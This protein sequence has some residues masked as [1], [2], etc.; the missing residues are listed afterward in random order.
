M[1]FEAL[2][3]I[4]I[5]WSEFSSFLFCVVDLSEPSNWILEMHFG[6]YEC[7]TIWV[8]SG[9]AMPFKN[10]LHF[11]AI[12]CVHFVY[13]LVFLSLFFS[14]FLSI[15]MFCLN[16]LTWKLTW[17]KKW[18]LLLHKFVS[19]LSRSR[20]FFLISVYKLHQKCY[21]WFVFE[22]WQRNKISL[23]FPSDGMEAML[24]CSIVNNLDKLT[25][26][27]ARKNSVDRQYI[28]AYFIICC[29]NR[30]K[31]L[32]VFLFDFSAHLTNGWMDS[33]QMRTK[34]I[35]L[36]HLLFVWFLCSSVSVGINNSNITN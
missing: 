28:V 8:S 25:I 14:L 4:I 3:Y 17:I 33:R 27:T 18:I 12:V 31:M 20:A 19:M 2:S 13:V 32:W 36:V 24:V 1:E 16:F 35:V 23:S 22:W 30:I 34:L 26:E 6:F 29:P 7:D 15:L 21:Q 11:V 5:V 9:N 10:T